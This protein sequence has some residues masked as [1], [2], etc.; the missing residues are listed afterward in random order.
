ME[1]CGCGVFY[2][3]K[4]GETLY[5]VAEKFGFSVGLFL[6]KNPYFNISSAKA[7]QVVILPISEVSLN[8][9]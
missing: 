3:L 6:A 7:G 5:D 9:T 4:Q 2:T 1:K 8:E